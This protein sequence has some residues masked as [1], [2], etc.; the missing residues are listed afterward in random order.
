MC[1]DPT[2]ELMVSKRV[3]GAFCGMI[4]I[5]DDICN[6][7]D[8]AAALKE[9]GSASHVYFAVARRYQP[10]PVGLVRQC[11]QENERTHTT[12]GGSRRY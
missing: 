2:R 4:M 6:A 7:Q 5:A 8:G 1:A 3:H 9:R 12:S 11:K 10:V